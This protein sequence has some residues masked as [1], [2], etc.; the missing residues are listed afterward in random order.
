MSDY[1]WIYYL[2]LLPLLEEATFIHILNFDKL[3]FTA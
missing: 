2:H 1:I 3:F